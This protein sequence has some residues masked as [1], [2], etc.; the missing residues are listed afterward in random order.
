MSVLTRE[1]I[2]GIDAILEGAQREG[3][4]SLYE[5]EVYGILSCVG[6]TVP[7]FHFVRDPRE[8]NEPGSGRSAPPSW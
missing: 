7:R 6:L 4:S 8:V 3:R 1:A 5:H 2:C